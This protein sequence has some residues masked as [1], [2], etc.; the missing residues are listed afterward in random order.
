MR[1]R[2]ADPRAP[3]PPA[4]AA[5]IVG[6]AAASDDRA[7]V[8]HDLAEGFGER[9]ATHGLRHARVWYWRQTLRSAGPLIDRRAWRWRLARPSAP[10]AELRG[11]LR[12]AA[13]LAARTPA[14]SL[15]VVLA[16]AL[17]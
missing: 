12:Y 6:R 3:R 7:D 2:S 5:W 1:T 13:R 17:G 8:L 14:V 10:M 4:L 16:M 11:D 9:L 15:A